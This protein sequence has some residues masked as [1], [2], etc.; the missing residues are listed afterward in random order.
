MRPR[1]PVLPSGPETVERLTLR[2]A[3][4]NLAGPTFAVALAGLLLA[5][6]VSLAFLR[7]GFGG[8]A[9]A[10]GFAAVAAGVVVLWLKLAGRAC[11][12]D[13]PEERTAC[14]ARQALPF[15][16]FLPAGVLAPEF[17]FGRPGLG[18]IG[19]VLGLCF[20]LFAV[21]FGRLSGKGSGFAAWIGRHADALTIGFVGAHA[22]LTIVLVVIRHHYY[23]PVLGEDTGYYNQIFWSTLQGEFFRGSLTQARYSDPPISSEFGAHNSPILFL[24]LPAYWI[25]PSFYTLLV[26]RNLALSASALP[27]YFLAKS[28]LDGAVALG[29]AVCYLLSPNLIYQSV[30][31][32][33]PLQFAALFLA[34]AFF[35]FDRD[36]FPLFMLFFLLALSVREEIAL[37]A[38]LFGVYAFFLRR[39]WRW[40][41]T[42]A[43]LSI[44]WWYISVHLVM[45]PSRIALEDLEEFYRVFPNGFSSAPGV[46]IRHPFEFMRL[47][48]AWE[49]VA[50]LYQLLKSTAGMALA[51]PAILFIFPATLINLIVGAFWKTTTSIDMHYSLV[52]S[53]CLSV[54]LVYGVAR[55]ARLHRLFGTGERAFAL[56]LTLLLVPPI[57]LGVKDIISYGSGSGQTLLSDFLPRPYDATLDRIAR[58]IESEPDAA[59]A[60]PSILLPRLSRRRELYNANRLWRYGNPR[61]DY[62]VVQDPT[63]SASGDSPGHH[64]AQYK[65]LVENIGSD[66]EN[67]LLLDEH[68]FRLYR[69]ER[70]SSE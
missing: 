43:V 22:L 32:F 4:R 13:D 18:R 47:I 40:V 65:A 2:S 54:A 41:V 70:I 64:V 46:L 68:G 53:V 8:P 27:V 11:G 60:A 5:T 10:A 57:L 20:F 25:H 55:L 26:L 69:V 56:T 59:I 19:M 21:I 52:A 33:Y 7:I 50:Y 12:H 49:N 29:L 16:A 39:A 48:F 62:I 15:L 30:G 31:A 9:A 1:P 24:L 44:I 17:A 23:N 38:V 37:T 14:F 67:R 28:R 58:V 6:Y 3:S 63:D 51:T 35:F 45:V 42:P 34:L 66:P 36:R 61:L